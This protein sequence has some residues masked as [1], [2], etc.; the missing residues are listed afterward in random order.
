MYWPKLRQ[1]ELGKRLTALDTGNRA[2]SGPPRA[3]RRGDESN[4]TKTLS[5]LRPIKFRR[6]LS[7]VRSAIQ[8]GRLP[9][10]V[11]FP[12]SVSFSP[13]PPPLSSLVIVVSAL[14]LPISPANAETHFHWLTFAH[15]CFPVP[16]FQR[17]PCASVSLGGLRICGIHDY[18]TVSLSLFVSGSRVRGS[19]S[20]GSLSRHV[21]SPLFSFLYFCIRTPVILAACPTSSIQHLPLSF[22][23]PIPRTVPLADAIF[24]RP[25]DVPLPPPR[26]RI[27]A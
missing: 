10:R 23:F 13:P 20:P 11:S 4:Y 14:P 3:R 6:L 18:P 27:H 12:P 1:E 2:R 24:R 9:S 21:P 17:L 25:V 5:H 22:C 19:P 15:R 16:L 26:S 7:S 8:S